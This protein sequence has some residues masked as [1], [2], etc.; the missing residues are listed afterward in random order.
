MVASRA[1]R[2]AILAAVLV[3]ALAARVLG[4]IAPEN[5]LVL[6]NQGSA[7][8]AQVA[9]YYAQAHP[10]VRLL[11]L[12]GVGLGE[13]ISAT[14]YL[15]VLRPQVMAALTPS[16]DVIVTTKGLPLRIKVDQS[17]PFSYTDPF[18]V[19]RTAYE[20]KQYSSL[21]SELAQI[22]KISTWQQMGDQTWWIPQGYPSYPQQS[23]NLYY[24]VHGSFD[25]EIYG[26]RLTSRLDGFTVADVTASIDRAR[27]AFVGGPYGFVVD[28]DPNAPGA[29]VNRMAALAAALDI[30]NMPYIYDNT[31]AFVTDTN[32]AAPGPVL[33]YVSYGVHGGGKQAPNDYLVDGGLEGQLTFGLADGAVFHTW[34]SYNA[35]S[36]VPG[37]NQGGQGLVAEWIA[38]GGT[39]GTGHVQEPGA[40]PTSVTNEDLMFKMLLDGYTW[41]EA[42]WS[43]T[44]QLSFV[45]TVVGDP[46]MVFRELIAGDANKDGLVGSID[47]ALLGRYWGDRGEPGTMWGQGDFNGDGLV[48]SIDLAILGNQ[49]GSTA[50]WYS[51]AGGMATLPEPFPECLFIP[52]PSALVLTGIG[53]AGLLLRSG[54]FRRR[55]GQGG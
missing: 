23:R 44:Q 32:I 7:E 50:D 30:A 13:Q 53:L 15:G 21:E 31:D 39:V 24:Q 48:G 43:A 36:F 20:W 18:G 26:S 2:P 42:A 17:N 34:E 1:G 33:G 4:A 51:R 46:L 14:D 45:N 12:S 55:P 40:N 22:D 25:H 16:T 19:V 37:G 9:A 54:R 29:T 6:Y 5:V 52:E 10:G 28:N 8:G 11:G 41:A 27:G 35:Y 38:R 49:W 3:A 47:L